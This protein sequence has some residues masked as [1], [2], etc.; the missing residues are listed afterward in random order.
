MCR[1]DN[2]PNPSVCALSSGMVWSLEIFFAKA[3]WTGTSGASSYDRKSAVAADLIQRPEACAVSIKRRLNK[4]G[5]AGGASDDPPPAALVITRSRDRHDST[6][7][8]PGGFYRMLND[9][10]GRRRPL[11]PRTAPVGRDL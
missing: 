6:S 3:C 1:L 5:A 7:D 4:C 10:E 11:Y 9:K 8:V 2:A